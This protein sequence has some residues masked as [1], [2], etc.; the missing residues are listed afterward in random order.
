VDDSI[1]TQVY[2]NISFTDKVREAV[3]ETQGI[4]VFYED[5]IVDT[6]VYFS[7]SSGFTAN[8]EEVWSYGSKFPGRKIPYLR[9]QPQ[10]EGM[11]VPNLRDEA[12][13]DWF[14][15]SWRW[16]FV[17]FYDS[18]SP[19]FRWKVTLTR[20]QLENI[21]SKTIPQRERADKIL[22]AD[23]VRVIEGMD[24][25]DPNFSIGE[26][27]DLRV[28]RRGEGGNVM[29]LE[30]VGTNGRWQI[31]KEYNI[32]FVIRPRKD[33][34][35]SKEDII[36]HLYNGKVIKNYSILPSAFFTMDIERDKDG[37]IE[38]V[39]FY[40]GGNGHGVGMSQYGARYLGEIGWNYDEIVK[41]F[42][43]GVKLKKI[44]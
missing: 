39:T 4:V 13:A 6:M 14:F 20:E 10:F 40:G 24:P 26:L 2:N 1:S 30:I 41:K 7:T 34:A 19:W 22:K 15:R 5:E 18:I 28:I 44:Y 42:Y 12:E 8:V 25:S 38:T 36:L 35:K 27:L 21:M 16:F 43:H 33:F 3:K 31:D 11:D 29:T 9:A 23:F 37:R 17:K 32:R